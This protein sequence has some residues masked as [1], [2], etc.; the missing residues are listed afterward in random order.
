MHHLK[1]LLEALW[2]IT[3]YNIF[4]SKLYQRIPQN[5]PNF[6][7][8]VGLCNISKLMFSK[9]YCHYKYKA[10]YSILAM[11]LKDMEFI[12]AMSNC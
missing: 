12:F 9:Q 11:Y 5:E 8:F 3:L 1:I 7:A 4:N 2:L 10:E 6:K